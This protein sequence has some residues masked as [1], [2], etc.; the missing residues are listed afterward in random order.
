MEIENELMNS[1]DTDL[2]YS[3]RSRS[4]DSRD[5]DNR[6]SK[7]RPPIVFG[8]ISK[9]N[10]D[11]SIL[12]DT[13]YKFAFNAYMV[14]GEEIPQNFYTSQRNGWEPVEASEYPQARRIYKHDPFRKRESEDELIRV[15]GQ[16]LMRRDVETCEKE[17]Q[18]FDEEN[19]H[20]DNIVNMHK[21]DYGGTR[22][23][24]HSRTRDSRLKI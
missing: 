24:S 2:K 6:A 19:Y 7:E 22:V 21:G 10:L 9:Y 17:A 1:E 14:R 12:A 4:K 13:R 18:F 3:R 5:Y 23:F 15:D 16:I 11:E 20:K 8:H